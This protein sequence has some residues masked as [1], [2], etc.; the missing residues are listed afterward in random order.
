MRKR[1]CLGSTSTTLPSSKQHTRRQ[2]GKLLYYLFP[3]YCV[4][5]LA[6]VLQQPHVLDTSSEPSPKRKRALEAGP[7]SPRDQ[8]RDWS[9]PRSKRP[10]TSPTSDASEESAGPLAY[11]VRTRRWHKKYFEQ[12]SK[13]REAFERGKDP[14]ALVR[15][16]WLEKRHLKNVREQE[17]RAMNNLRYL[18][19]KKRSSPS[20]RC[21]NS[22]SNLQVSSNH[23]PREAKSAQYRNKDYPI[24][25][26]EEGSYMCKSELDITDDSKSLC[27]R[28]LYSEQN[29]PLDSLF[30]DDL[31]EKTC[32]KIQDRNEV[33][34]IRDISLLIVPSAQTFATYG[35]KHLDH[36]SESVNEGWDRAN[37]F[38][39][40]A[41]PQPDY[42]AGFSRL[43]FTRN[44]LQK[45]EPFVGSIGS[46]LTSYFIAT[47]R[48]YF[49][50]LTC[51]VKCGAAALDIAD[52]QNAHSMTLA[53]RG[54]VELYKLVKREKEI[55]RTILA[56]SVSHDHSAVRIYGHYALTDRAETTFYRHPIHKFDFT[57]LDGRDKWSAYK[58]TKNVYDTWMPDHLEK[59]RSAIDDLPPDINFEEL[60][61][62]LESQQ[63]QGLGA[64]QPSVTDS[65]SSCTGSQDVKP[66]TSFIQADERVFKKAKIR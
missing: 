11:W 34:V 46:K 3:S 56:F 65:Q 38:L 16:A 35:A 6:E 43:A 19:A 29:V 7:S 2:N 39:W 45:L 25:L 37:G 26:E 31:F 50:F 62:G 18:L 30:R 41:R 55:H 60:Q 54:V 15:E 49:P 44:Q 53:V 66:T 52:R 12:D 20:L 9:R 51:E 63:S 58:F 32:E 22:E 28:L 24:R 13:V 33:M 40:C 36:V 21:K 14:E 4:A 48:I 10:R 57:A 47:S 1:S 42:S 17:A 61:V 5:D 23:L 64:S 27:R 59:I 8:D